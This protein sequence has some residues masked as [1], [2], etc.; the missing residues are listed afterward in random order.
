MKKLLLSATT[1]VIMATALPAGAQFQKSED[2]VKYRQSAFFVMGQ[3]FS[4]IGAMANN[5]APFD[6][7]AAAESAGV[8]A[9][10]ST[11]PFAGFVEGSDKGNTKARPEIWAERAKFDSLAETMQQE[12]A[13][14]EVAAQGGNEGEIK[15]AF[16]AVGQ[17][18]KACHDD[19]RA[20]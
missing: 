14:L 11:L 5:R 10:M 3:H 18:C 8:V 2:A 12:V 19:Y 7:K 13:K 6:A 17:S 20:R 15:S 9:T 16:G 1:L 4:R